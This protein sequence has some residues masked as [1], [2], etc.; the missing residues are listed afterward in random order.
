MDRHLIHVETGVTFSLFSKD[1]LIKISQ[2]FDQQYYP[3]L[4]EFSALF[5]LAMSYPN[6]VSYSDLIA[7]ISEI[8]P[9]ISAKSQVD[10]MFAKIKI[11][12][13]SF[14]VKDLII[15]TKLKGYAISNKWVPP[16]EISEYSIKKRFAKM[17]RL[18]AAME[19]V[20][21]HSSPILHSSKK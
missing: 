6:T 11:D 10:K 13:K 3:S 1:K 2:H 20:P 16:E 5:F 15:K 8:R 9:E 18:V 19:A 7:I 4:E 21:H 17:L 14:G 12:L